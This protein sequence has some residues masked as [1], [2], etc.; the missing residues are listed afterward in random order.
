VTPTPGPIATRALTPFVCGPAIGP[1]GR[2]RGFT[3][4]VTIRTGGP[5]NVTLTA[6]APTAA[7]IVEASWRVPHPRSTATAE[8]VGHAAVH[9][10]A[11]ASANLLA[12]GR[13]PQTG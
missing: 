10:L 7:K 12:A 6:T 8:R 11:Q 5:I 4:Y 3:T 1:S 2:R 9:E 13:E